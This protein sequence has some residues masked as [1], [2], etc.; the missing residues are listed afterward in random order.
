MKDA[1]SGSGQ[2]DAS[3][4]RVSGVVKWFDVS[5]GF[6][7]MVGDG[8]EGDVLLHFSVLREH[9][10]RALPEGA[11]VDCVAA[12]RERGLQARR[13]LAI[14]LSCAIG[15]D[16]DMEIPRPRDHADHA[17]LAATAGAFEP[18]TVKWFN[19]LKG[20][21]FI[22]RDADAATDI[23]LHMEVVRRAGLEGIEPGQPLAARIAA[24]RKGPLAVELDERGRACPD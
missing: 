2:Y 16:P 17:A 7:F 15:P 23:F 11:R 1:D 22:V 10:R 21:G 5:R 6:G 8:G 9:A 12:R 18:V 14:D 3:E 20:Y 13:V 24:G 4:S 19:R